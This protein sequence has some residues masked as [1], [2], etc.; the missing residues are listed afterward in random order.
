LVKD[1]KL[2]ILVAGGGPAGL[3]IAG[4]VWRLIQDQGGESLITLLAGKKLMGNFPDK[5]RH[6]ASQS[7]QPARSKLLKGSP[8]C[9]ENGYAGWTTA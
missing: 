5:V 9:P 7:F 2:S 1:R 8:E 6:L 3:E 4:N